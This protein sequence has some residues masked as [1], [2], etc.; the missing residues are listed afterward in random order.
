LQPDSVG[1]A[2]YVLWAVRPLST[3]IHLSGQIVLPQC[4]VNGLNSSLPL[5]GQVHWTAVWSQRSAS[6]C[7]DHWA[8]WAGQTFEH[9][10]CI[11]IVELIEHIIVS[12]H[13]TAAFIV[14]LLLGRT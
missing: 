7:L 1:K 8:T 3:F 6:E 5:P 10:T 11:V 4:L 2:H 13:I 14:R 9:A 12:Y